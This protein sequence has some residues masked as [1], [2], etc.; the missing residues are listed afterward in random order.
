MI[1]YLNPIIYIIIISISLSL[2]GCTSD[3]EGLSPN[4]TQV[5]SPE[6]LNEVEIATRIA[7]EK[8]LTIFEEYQPEDSEITYYV[9]KNRYSSID[10]IDAFLNLYYSE[11]MTNSIIENYIK[12]E[13]V[14]GLG[15]ITTLNLPD[16]Y[17]TLTGHELNNKDSIKIYDNE[18]T[19]TVNIKDQQ[20]TYSLIKLDN[21]WLVNG[22]TIK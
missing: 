6:Q 20:L 11:E 9:G 14:P 13:E 4:T 10:N 2:V 18:A 3:S 22:K 16:N 12:L 1:R 5:I 19:I 21:K 8:L 7:E 15:I 17:L